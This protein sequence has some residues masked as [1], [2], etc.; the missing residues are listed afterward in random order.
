MSCLGVERRL[1]VG[2]LVGALFSIT[3]EQ[4][5]SADKSAHSKSA[6]KAVHHGDYFV[7]RL[8]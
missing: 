7:I 2:R 4:G 1:E 8:E 6:A 5:Q 3:L